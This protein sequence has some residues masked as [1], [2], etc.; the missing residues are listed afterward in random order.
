MLSPDVGKCGSD[1]YLAAPAY[2]IFRIV[3]YR[4]L[5]FQG[6]GLNR[7]LRMALQILIFHLKCYL[8]VLFQYFS[9]FERGMPTS[10]GR[11]CQVFF[12]HLAL[13]SS[14]KTGFVVF[15][16]FYSLNWVFFSTSCQR[17]VT[18]CL[19]I[20]LKDSRTITAKRG[21]PCGGL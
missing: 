1:V 3:F 6:V 11:Q 21:R 14:L 19:W 7:Y 4:S 12:S 9:I 16:R 2:P 13:Q 18:G 10:K 5:I 17:W 20:W 8:L 15:Q